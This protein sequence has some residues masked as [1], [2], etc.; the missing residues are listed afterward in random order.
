MHGHLNV[1]LNLLISKLSKA[2]FVGSVLERLLLTIYRPPQCVN[3][4]FKFPFRPLKE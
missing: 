3:L 4:M 2:S 1:K